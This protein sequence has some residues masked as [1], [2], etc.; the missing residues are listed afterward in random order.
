[1]RWHTPLTLALQRQRRQADLCEFKASLIYRV[2]F[3][4]DRAT[5]RNPV[6][7]QINKNPET[8]KLTRALPSELWSQANL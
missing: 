1:V 2:S 6:S 4:T 7:N 3:R 8:T 5:K